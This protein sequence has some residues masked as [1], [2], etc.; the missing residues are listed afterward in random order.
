MRP[1]RLGGVADRLARRF[2]RGR[3]FK[4]V[5]SIEPGDDWAAEIMAAVGSC[6]VLLAVI[7]PA[8]LTAANVTGRRLDDPGDLVRL[9]I[10]TA[11]ARG[12][13]VIPILVDG[14]RMPD[15][16]DLPSD[17]A[18][19]TARQ[20]VDLRSDRFAADLD[21]LTDALVRHLQGAAVRQMNVVRAGEADAVGLP[22]PEPPPH[23][24]EK[25][26]PVPHQLPVCTSYFVGRGS[27][28]RKL[29]DLLEEAAHAAGPAKA[30]TAV[31][32]VIAGMGGIGKTALTLHWAHE[33]SGR[34]PDGQLY[35]NLRGFGPARSPVAPSEA[36]RGFL[37]ALGIEPE[38][39]P[40]DLETQSALYRS[41]IAGQRMLIVL[42]NA[43]D[44]AQLRPLL[45]GSETC[46]VVAT[47][48]NQ[49]GGLIAQEG[50][51]LLTLNPLTVAEAGELLARQL[52]LRRVMAECEAAG[53]IRLVWAIAAGA[54]HRGSPSRDPA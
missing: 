40:A 13:R 27:E 35:V 54:E 43:H 46:L 26:A 33:V 8:W 20:A 12:V 4:D 16:S 11:L 41:L 48:R 53:E 28:L 17:L 39:I 19:L 25:A 22:L 50:A 5:T 47:S 49:L 32:C 30:G 23:R 44:C 1:L 15:P 24:H 2:G 51:R 14:A 29:A 7:G 34:F 9:E 45:P 21:D 36:L 37:D 31:I 6:V 52:G 38:K 10:R 3:V 42:D 18:Q